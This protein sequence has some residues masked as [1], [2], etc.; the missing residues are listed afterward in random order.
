M[1]ILK[2]ELKNLNSL[3]G[4]WT[5]DLTD[6]IFESN[7]I[8]AI[9]GSTGAGKTTIFDAVCLALYGQTPR[10]GKI[11]TK[12]N[13]IMSR[14]TDD[15][16]AKVVFEIDN[17]E[18]FLSF[19]EQYRAGKSKNKN[20]N[21][22]N[23]THKLYKISD[24]SEDELEIITESLSETQNKIQELIGL[25]FQRFRQAVML[26]QGGFD[27][28]LKAKKNERAEILELLTGTEIYGEIS[29]KVYDRMKIEERALN[30]IKFKLENI[31]PKD[32]FENEAEISDALDEARNNS[33]SVTAA[34]NEAKVA[35][36]WL[37]GIQKIENEL[38]ENSREI[39][40]L[41]KRFELFTTNSKRLEIGQRA[42]ELTP[43][44]SILKT[45]RENYQKLNLKAD[46]LKKDISNDSAIISEIEAK[47]IPTL[48]KAIREMKKNFLPD[49]SPESF[50]AVVRERYKIFNDFAMQKKRIE[51]EKL[52]AEKAFQ[53]AQNDLKKQEENLN[54]FQKIKDEAQKKVDDLTDMRLDV[55]LAT[56]RMNLK[57]GE[58]C[59]LCGSREHPAFV[60]DPSKVKD[61]VG[62]DDALKIARSKLAVAS[63]NL[64]RAKNSFTISQK[65]E[66]KARANLDNLI[67]EYSKIT[68]RRAEEKTKMST[69]LDKLEI[70]VTVVQQIPPKVN[71]W[72]TKLKN[73]E[74]NLKRLNEQRESCKVRIE[75]RQNSLAGAISEIEN[76]RNELDSLEKIFAEKL[77]EK[78][79]ESEDVFASS[80]I[81]ADEIKKLASL[82][83]ELEN[84]KT[85]LHGIKNN[86]EKKLAAEKEK[87]IT[88][89]TLDELEPEIKVRDEFLK[90]LTRKIASLE[91]AL[92]NHKKLQR[93]L[94]KLNK[95][96]EKQEKIF[97]NW[98]DLSKLIGSASGY[99]FRV[100]AQNITLSKMV[101][102]A[103]EQLEKMNGRY[104]LVSR[105]D[106]DELDLSVIDNEQAG[107]I[108]PTEN[109]SGGE[110][111]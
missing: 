15:C 74:E 21:F 25:D 11:G 38:A 7:G 37:K 72:L 8:F 103:N 95:E 23:P 88:Q 52:E 27:A 67:S 43:D 36:D 60:H 86:F 66:S 82:K 47:K 111:F 94:N 35:Y 32:D 39:S 56:E 70:K 69:L 6:G 51:D 63:E 98:S 78:N 42:A 76:A 65:E 44:F 30:D 59:P 62:F 81:D 17:G 73:I 4:K 85:K 45:K 101:D 93:E 108:R 12:Q 1:K 3:R 68:E 28:F 107:E 13:E 22:L 90:N 46:A 57:P 83:Q 87:S 49:E 75:T 20:K 91:V 33:E 34:Q 29:M 77:R 106:S 104:I 110:R 109:L 99:N 105:P 53:N 2:I 26:E 79:F 61:I 41:E 58:P 40:Q 24:D 96:Y 16:Y 10:L 19:W 31:K 84:D 18:K 9:T 14:H 71:E 55:I 97:S 50:C 92:E 100:F 54:K 102:L 89:K 80:I 5:I 64:N 48:D